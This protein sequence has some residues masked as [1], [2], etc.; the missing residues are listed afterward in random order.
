MKGVVLK[1]GTKI[2]YLMNGGGI[3][4]TDSTKSGAYQISA[5]DR[6]ID[7]EKAAA[8]IVWTSYANDE[9]EILDKVEIPISK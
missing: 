6:V 1:D 2:P 5:Y 7:V 4:Y 9:A 8:L 3:G